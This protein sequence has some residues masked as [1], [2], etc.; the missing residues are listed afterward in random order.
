MH[1]ITGGKSVAA[2]KAL[3]FHNSKVAAEIAIELAKL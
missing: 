1:E 2:N 3:V